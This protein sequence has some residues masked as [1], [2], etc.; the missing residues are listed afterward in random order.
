MFL[1]ELHHQEKT[2]ASAYLLERLLLV[3][4]RVRSPTAL[5]PPLDV[6]A[7]DVID[8]RAILVITDK[9]CDVHL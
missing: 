6:C 9:R 7:Y 1:N 3:G 2:P 5:T 4:S 8:K